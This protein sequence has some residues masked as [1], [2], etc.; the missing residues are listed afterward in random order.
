MAQLIVIYDPNDKI[1][2][3][4][5]RLALMGISQVALRIEDLPDDPAAIDEL[6]RKLASL[7]LAAITT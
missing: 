6:A 3:P 2:A 5:E 4:T 7:L 1:T